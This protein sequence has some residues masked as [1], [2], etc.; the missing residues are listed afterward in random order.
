MKKI[1]KCEA[2]EKKNC[3]CNKYIV[4]IIA[5]LII[6]IM[7]LGFN[8]QAKDKD[9]APT[10][11]N[12]TK[13]L[14]TGSGNEPGWNVKVYGVDLNGKSFKTDFILDYGDAKYS[15]ILGRSADD[16]IGT[17]FQF[18]GDVNL[19]VD[20]KISSSTKN[21]ILYF[22]KA[23]CVDDSGATK[24]YKVDLNLNSEKQYKGCADL[25]ADAK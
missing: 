3:H 20:D 15:G 13:L 2:K 22:E 18:R 8:K 16:N 10:E 17:N 12:T 25:V 14:V 5:I 11:N 9:I 23:S 21:V 6:L 4:A 1:C 7:W 24:N 19:V